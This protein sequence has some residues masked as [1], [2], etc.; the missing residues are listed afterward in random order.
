MVLPFLTLLCSSLC[1]P[2]TTH[3]Y[4]QSVS[5]QLRH[6]PTHITTTSRH[7]RAPAQAPVRQE[8]RFLDD[9]DVACYD[10]YDSSLAVDDDLDLS[11]HGRGDMSRDT[12]EDL[13]ESRVLEDIFFIR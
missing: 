2:S 10:G 3:R 7:V 5:A 11:S 4:N 13:E 9:I 12:V 1:R 6:K 8:G